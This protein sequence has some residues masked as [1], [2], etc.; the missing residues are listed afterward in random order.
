MIKNL[1]S[2]T[3]LLLSLNVFSQAFSGMY[4]FSSVGTGT[5]ST[6]TTDPT[7]PPTA[8]GLTF[9]SFSAVGTGTTPSAGGVF[10]FSGWDLGATN[11]IDTYTTFTGALN[12]A[13]YYEVTL[14]PSAG[15]QI[16]LTSITFNMLRSSTGPR[17]WSVRSNK[18]TYG[19][20]LPA[21]VG[22]NTALSVVGSNEFFWLFDATGNTAQQKG[23]SIALS[24]ANFTNQT[25]PYTFRFYSWNAESSA[26]TFRVDTVTFTGLAT[27]GAGIA[28]YTQDL[29]ST[30]KIYPNPSNDGIVY[31]DTKKINY[32]KLEVV[33][34]LGSVVA[35]EDKQTTNSEKIRLDL[36]TLPSGT[37]FMRI[38]SGNKIYTE[39]F[40]IAK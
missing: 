39:R 35:T 26:G 18:D 31:L 11:G 40:F 32:S 10:A 16:N 27:G 8:A 15:Y 24:G 6:G 7:P 1:L 36:N 28:D 29:N 4:P 30:I 19:T 21:S 12:P 37:Y 9:G 14:T 17:N 22:T 3:L 38:T 20:N 25:T 33:N 2:A 13:K 5:A 34:I 23:C